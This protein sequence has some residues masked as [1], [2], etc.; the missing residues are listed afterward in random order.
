MRPFR[1][2]FFFLAALILTG[3]SVIPGFQGQGTPQAEVLFTPTPMLGGYTQAADL[4]CPIAQFKTITSTDQQG[5]LAAW[6]PQGDK[7]AFIKPQSEHAMFFGDLVVASGV[8]FQEQQTV[9]SEAWGGLMWSPSGEQIAYVSLRPNDNVYTVYVTGL[10]G[11]QPVDLFPGSEAALDNYSSP[12]MIHAWPSEGRLRVYAS[13]GMGCYE[14]I[15]VSVPGGTKTPVSSTIQTPEP[16]AIASAWMSPRTVRDYDPESMPELNDPA[17][18]N[19][20]NYVV[21][22]D[23]DGYMWVISTANKTAAPVEMVN[24]SVLPIFFSET[25]KREMHWASNGLLAVRIE[26]ELELFSV[27]CN[28]EQSILPT[29]TE[30]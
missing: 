3:C 2:C 14:E 13:C 30:E 21:Y 7:I 23:E 26:N 17:W 24:S 4:V 1:F 10:D 5:S 16:T 8:G 29:P 19:D 18:S 25:W 27:P 6:S 15:E 28:L 22:F 9:A 11:R 20:G 12:K